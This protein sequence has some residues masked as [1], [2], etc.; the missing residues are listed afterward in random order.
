MPDREP[1]QRLPDNDLRICGRDRP[2]PGLGERVHQTL[3]AES[4]E[5]LP[6]QL[7]CGDQQRMDLMFT[8]GG[9]G[10]LALALNTFDVQ[11]EADA[12]SEELYTEIGS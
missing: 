6:H 11:L 9:Y 7:G 2:R 3:P 10:T 5:R 1:P 4:S 12:G 8:V